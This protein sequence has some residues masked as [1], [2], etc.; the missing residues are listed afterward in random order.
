[1]KFH[2]D[3]YQHFECIVEIRNKKANL[4]TWFDLLDSQIRNKKSTSYPKNKKNL[5]IKQ[6]LFFYSQLHLVARAWLRNDLKYN[7]KFFNNEWWRT[8]VFFRCR[9]LDLKHFFGMKIILFQFLEFSFQ[10][11]FVFQNYFLEWT[12]PRDYVTL[13]SATFPI[14]KF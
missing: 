5:N 10:D 14:C 7:F 2:D 1:M 13:R 12:W 8:K 3:I 9:Y 11:F 6:F 4:N